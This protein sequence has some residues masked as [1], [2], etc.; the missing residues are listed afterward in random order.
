ME[1]QYI[2]CAICG[3]S[4][5]PATVRIVC[6]S[7]ECQHQRELYLMRL[8]AY[9][10]GKQKRKPDPTKYQ[11]QPEVKKETLADINAKAL[12]AGMSYGEYRL[13]LTMRKETIK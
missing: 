2:N 12:E 6:C 8:K 5:L 3:K 9:E 4:F 11:R 1:R 13:Y 10:N 7:P